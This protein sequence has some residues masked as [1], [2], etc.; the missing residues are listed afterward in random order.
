MRVALL[1][2]FIPPYR[3]SLYWVLNNEVDD[4]T[5]FISQEMEKNRNWTVDHGN[6]SVILQKGIRYKKKWKNE[7][8]Y[9]DVTTV[10]MP[11]DTIF[12][13]RTYKPDVVISAELGMRSLFA[14]IY[15]QLYKKPLVLWLALSEHTEKNKK[16]LRLL[17]RKYILRKA[18]A[19]L[20]NGKSGER[21]ICSLGIHK[22]I[23][24]VPYTSD[25]KI[26]SQ[27]RGAD[28]SRKS[29]LL[30]G[31]LIPRKGIAET[32]KVLQ[33]WAEKNKSKNIILT[34][35][36]DGPERSKL[37][38]LK[39]SSNIELRLLGS[40]DYNEIQKLY[41]Q[42]D[43]YLFPTLGDEWGVVVNE[44]MASG[45]PV[46]GS[47]YSQA[48]DELVVENE[49]GWTFQPNDEESFFSALSK[50]LGC[51]SEKLYKMGEECNHTIRK[52]TAEAVAKEI[53]KALDFAMEK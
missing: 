35:A 12:K 15:C 1:T 25:F 13:L 2:N 48:V 30:T 27:E 53:K 17:L 32:A 11:L 20:V 6:L 49:T 28:K 46:L 38:A 44:A 10:Q 37:E 21:Y 39:N 29:I 14:A 23:F 22:K 47:V 40:V 7:L 31:Q 3:K 41:Q 26:N 50:A 16:G 9:S 36:G 19:I 51:S 45:T 5:I 18:K 34:V 42:H 24:F 33:A 8:G 52:F 43:I 4:L